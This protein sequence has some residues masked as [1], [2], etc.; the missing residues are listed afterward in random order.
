MECVTIFLVALAVAWVI[1]AS[2]IAERIEIDLGGNIDHSVFRLALII[3]P[4]IFLILIY[5][6][7]LYLNAS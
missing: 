7:L 2:L 4:V 5:M 6:V 1:F 3:V